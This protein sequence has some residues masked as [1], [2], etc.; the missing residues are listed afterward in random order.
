MIDA[1]LVEMFKK[2]ILYEDDEIIAVNKPVNIASQ[3]GVK[4]QNSLDDLAKAVYSNAKLMHR[5]DRGTSG[6]IF[7][8]KNRAAASLPIEDKT[9]FA[10][11]KG[12]PYSNEGVLRCNL[13]H[14]K[15]REIISSTG[16]DSISYYKI[17]SNTTEYSY[18]EFKLET[19]RKHQIRVQSADILRCHVLGDTKY[20]S[21]PADRLYL[22]SYA[23]T[24]NN[25]RITAPLTEDFKSKLNELHL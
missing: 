15:E 8:G 6:L 1:G 3:G 16:K 10:I 24:V 12:V 2:W 23:A 25:K 17:V 14:T 21:I 18:A 4:I 13:E 7:L 20:G 19:G 5:I 9:Y 11:L 22:H